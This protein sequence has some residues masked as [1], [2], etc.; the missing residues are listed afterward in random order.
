MVSKK[1]SSNQITSN[2]SFMFEGPITH[3]WAKLLTI[4]KERN[5]ITLDFLRTMKPIST[6]SKTHDF[7]KKSSHE[8]Y[9]IES[10][11]SIVMPI[12]MVDVQTID[13]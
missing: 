11:S 4:E 13:E 8:N 3:R 12:I 7:G 10:K 6:N 5:V 1:I 2:K 9:D